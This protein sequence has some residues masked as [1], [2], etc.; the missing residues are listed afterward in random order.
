[1]IFRDYHVHLENGP[2]T[3]DWIKR[4]IEEGAKRGIV[5]IGFSEHGH[6]FVQ[7][8]G[9]YRSSGFRGQWTA[10]EATKNIEE[11]IDIVEKAKSMGLPVKLGIEM[12][13]IPEY[14]DEIREFVDKYPF[15]YVLGAVH[16]IG[17]FGFDNP[18]LLEEW[19][20]R[21]I[22]KTYLEYFDI[23]LKAI[24][25]GIFDCI[26]HPDVI[27][28]FGHRAMFDMNQTYKRV[29]E[30]MKKRGLCAEV[31]TAGLRKPV[32]EIYPSPGM[33]EHFA[34]CNVPVMINSDA[35]IPE[36]VG[37]DFDKALD[38]VKHYGYD[39]LCYFD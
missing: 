31:S 5:E 29:A 7:A 2:Y 36:D 35:H 14:E 33:M 4:F 37:R 1:M 20:S 24:D 18:E 16:W 21:N 12:D 3:I 25:S 19:N 17:D 13:Y 10:G 22:D 26:V 34:A 11:Y 15:D 39:R 6:R 9:L 28:V 23:L 38:F 30:A 32:A 8:K 27:K